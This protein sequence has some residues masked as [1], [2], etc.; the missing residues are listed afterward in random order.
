MISSNVK[1]ILFGFALLLL[2]LCC[3]VLPLN[4]L[5]TIIAIGGRWVGFIAILAGIFIPNK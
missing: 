2:S 1:A 5:S 4:T 3:A